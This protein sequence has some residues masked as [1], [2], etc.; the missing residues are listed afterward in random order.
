MKANHKKTLKKKK[1]LFKAGVLLCSP[2]WTGICEL[3]A[4]NLLSSGT[5][6]TARVTNFALNFKGTF[7]LFIAEAKPNTSSA[8]E[9]YVLHILESGQLLKTN[10]I[11]SKSM[12]MKECKFRLSVLPHQKLAI[13]QAA[14][15][16]LQR[17]PQPT[18]SIAKAHEHP[19]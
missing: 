18:A 14:S 10:T 11:C 19:F 13:G 5:T 17:R 3:P 9:F 15:A 2:V 1:N 4:S 8:Q 12:L 16:D 6:G 7:Q